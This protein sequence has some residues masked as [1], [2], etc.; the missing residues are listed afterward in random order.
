ME[1]PKLEGVSISNVAVNTKQ[2]AWFSY[3]RKNRSNL[4]KAVVL[5]VE[6][7]VAQKDITNALA[8]ERIVSSL[9]GLK[10]DLPGLGEAQLDIIDPK[11]E[12]EKKNLVI[13]GVL[14]TKGADKDTGVPI[15]ITSEPKLIGN[16]R[17][18]IDNLKVDSDS[19]VEPE[20]FAK[21]VSDLI[22]PVVDFGRYDTTTQAFR[23][24]SFKIEDN[25][26]TG[27][28]ELLLVPPK[29]M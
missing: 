1:E 18:V 3:K 4:K 14:I 16:Q 29:S 27:N 11:V 10:L 5:N 12:I 20:K 13:K 26:V 7:S 24:N 8:S 15:K 25:E 9:K 28:G 19:I 6:G 22:N 2:P 23:L 17:I 21:F